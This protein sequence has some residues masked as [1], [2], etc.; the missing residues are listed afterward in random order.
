ML[1][2]INFWHDKLNEIEN[3]LLHKNIQEYISYF[4]YQA[5]IG[6]KDK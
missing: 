1:K 6:V 2:K 4:K 3:Y 5:S